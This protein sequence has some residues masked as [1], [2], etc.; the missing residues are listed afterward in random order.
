[1]ILPINWLL[2]E[3]YSFHTVL[4]EY[5]TQS[6]YVSNTTQNANDNYL[7]I[8]WTFDQEIR[9]QLVLSLTWE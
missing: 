2:K 1:M 9:K 8:S 3:K 7:E 5:I 6:K 4:Y